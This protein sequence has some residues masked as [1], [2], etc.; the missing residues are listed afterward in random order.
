[1]HQSKIAEQEHLS[2]I[3]S[4][5]MNTQADTSK[6]AHVNKTEGTCIDIPGVFQKSTSPLVHSIQHPTSLALET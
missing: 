3:Y 4:S 5:N 1:M 2:K 6:Y